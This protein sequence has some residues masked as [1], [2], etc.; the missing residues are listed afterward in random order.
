[1]HAVL[2]GRLPE[3]QV[4]SH[5]LLE[6]S[7]ARCA[8]VTDIT[9]I[10]DAPFHADV[11]ASRVHR[12]TRGDWQLLPFLLQPAAL[13]RCAPINRWKMFDNLRRSLVAPMSLALLLLALAGHGRVALGR[14]GAGAGGLRRRA[15]D[16]RG[17]RLLA[18]PRRHRQAPLLP[19]GR[20]PTWCARCAAALWQ[21]A[22]LL[23]QALLA[24]DAIVRALYRMAVSRRHLLQWTTA[25][26][27]QARGQRP[28]WRRCCAGTGAS[29][30]SRWLL[31]GALLAAGTPHPALALALC[32]LWAASPVWTWWVSRPRPARADA[33]LPAAR[34]RLPAKASR[35]TPGA[36]SS[37][38]SA[39]TTTTC[40][41]TTCRPR[42]TTWWRTAPRRPTSAC[43]C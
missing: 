3:G 9:L 29:R 30:W 4:L 42:R 19:P 38:A 13:S 18:Q 40:R 25:A 6:G 10:E 17:G 36:S 11:A 33:A 21:L 39:P 12:W 41:P 32:L 8:A 31:L 20:R 5:D 7:L 24:L 1:M 14:A 27:A 28:A 26:A 16:G 22:Q 34:P 2:A 15:A 23:Q 35:A 37:A 43:T